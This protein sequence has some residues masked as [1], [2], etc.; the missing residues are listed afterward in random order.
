MRY[1][2]IFVY[3]WEYLMKLHLW[4]LSGM[5]RG[6]DCFALGGCSN[7]DLPC[8]SLL[9][10]PEKQLLFSLHMLS[11]SGRV[12]TK[13]MRVWNSVRRNYL[14]WN[15]IKVGVKRL[16]PDRSKAGYLKERDSNAGIEES[17]MRVRSLGLWH[18]RRQ[19][20]WWT[21][22]MGMAPWSARP[23]CPSKDLEW[24]LPIPTDSSS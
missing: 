10:R 9:H 18:H 2:C 5:E 3:I 19:S 23:S 22:A 12:N 11:G 16:Y 14:G 24:W 20:S 4:G 1:I 13:I 6:C 8:S 21:L 7:P 15:R 17:E